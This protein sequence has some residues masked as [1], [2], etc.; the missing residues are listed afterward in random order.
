MNTAVEQPLSVATNG[1]ITVDAYRAKLIQ[2]LNSGDSYSFLN[3]AEPFLQQVTDDHQIRLFIVRE[4]LKLGLIQPA[5]E[6][7]QIALD[8][9]PAPE[10]TALAATIKNL[11]GGV[12]PWAERADRFAKNLAAL[13]QRG[14]DVNPI[15]DA[16][17]QSKSNYE[18]HCDAHQV[19]QIRWRDSAGC[20]RWI[21]FLGHHPKI[22]AARELPSGLQSRMPM[23]I[24]LD[25]LGHGGYFERVYRATLDTFLGY[26]CALFIVEPDP[27]LFA[28]TLHLHDWSSLL[29][30]QRVFAF[31][32]PDYQTQMRD[33]WE[34]DRD[35]PWPSQV[36][37][38]WPQRTSASPAPLDVVNSLYTE[39]DTRLQQSWVDIETK[40]KTRDASYWSDR[41]DAALSGRGKPLRILAAVST[42]TT[43]LQYSMRD[44]KRAFEEL[45]YECVVLSESTPYDI[46]SPL[47]FHHAIRDLDPDL[48]F[49]IDHLR[50]EFSGIIPGNLPVFTWD[51]DQLPH[52]FTAENVKRIGPLDFL[53]GTTKSF[54]ARI[55]GQCDQFL[56][57]H[58]PTSAEQF[59]TEPLTPDEQ[60]AFAC[61]VSYVSHASQTPK[62][63]HDEER[64]QYSDPQLRRLLDVMFEQMPAMLREYRIPSGLVVTTLLRESCGRCGIAIKDEALRERLLWWYLWR[65]G[66]RFFRH[67]ALEW[68]AAWAEK[69]NRMLRIYGNGW[70]K[71]PTLA[72][73]A[74][75]LAKNGR[76]LVC[77]YRAS[78]INLQLM[79][80][81]FIH[82]RALDGLACGAFFLCRLVPNDLRGP[83]LK[84]LVARMRE[85]NISTARALLDSSDSQL[86]ELA[87]SYYGKN[88]RRMF[89]NDDAFLHSLY[90]GVELTGPDELFHG[91]HEI[92][93]D[94]ADEFQQKADSFLAE[95]D[96]RAAIASDMHRVAVD[97]FCYKKTMHRF[98]HAMA[99]RLRRISKP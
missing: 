9:M 59:N 63:F 15:R 96:Q 31:I 89:P 16:W 19:D 42:H 68:A 84:N 79:P 86:G 72:R 78:R 1:G 36:V 98:M 10:L 83:A 99:D 35:L 39:R 67:E 73:F 74:A 11:R 25:G 92:T 75:G 88:W 2:Q 85:L 76:E 26:S 50:H 87:I 52:V 29:A 43:F 21:P 51:Q 34:A 65:L 38:L 91:F 33:A 7:L 69:T 58:M 45:G 62:A 54:F 80:A 56:A 60:A 41:F 82:Q 57:S 40:Y 8:E 27:A 71:H 20:W 95:P 17:E 47:T 66:D 12:I 70:D 77:V 5:R 46:I 4:Y 37:S 18:L 90:Y 23:P 3:A 13:Q 30:D 81:G 22:D 49:N 93:F 44:A 28:L 48:F 55:G 24:L 64:N 97:Q 61:D 32:G 6:W 14:I 53:A 94:S